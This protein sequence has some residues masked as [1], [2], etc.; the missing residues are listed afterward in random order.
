MRVVSTNDNPIAIAADALVLAKFS[1]VEWDDDSR[2]IDQAVGE[3]LTRL[4]EYERLKGSVGELTTLPAPTGVQAK[5][6]VVAGL[7]ER[8]K[9]GA[10]EIRRAFGAAAKSI[11]SKACPRVVVVAPL[12]DNDQCESA[13]VAMQVGCVGQD[14]HRAEKRLNAFDE[15][16]WRGG[17]D[18]ALYRAA[19]L[20]QAVNLTR[21][22]VN[23]P[24]NIVYPTSFADRANQVA[25]E[26]GMEIEIWDQAKLEEE[27]C[28]SLL[29]VSR[30]SSQPPRLVILRWNGGEPGDAPLALVGKG[31]TFDS[32]G[33]SLKPSEGMKTMK[34]DMAGAA[35]V[36]G[37]MSA[38]SRL[39]SPTNVVAVMGLVENMVSGD[40]YKLGDVL[41][42]RSGK[43][44]EVLNTDA[45]GRLVLADAL[46]VVQD[47][48][49]SRIIDL[50][51]LTGACLVALGT[52]VAGLMANDDDWRQ[53]VQDTAEACGEAAWPLPMF[54]AFGEQIKSQVAD[55][56]NIGE[57]RWGGSITAAKFLEEFVDD[58]IPWTHIDIAGP[59]FFDSA[60]PWIDAGGAGSFVRT[61]ARIA[62]A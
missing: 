30:G 27:K 59:A 40:S 2:A 47:D 23:E 18:A 37:A 15:I 16:A 42:A 14:L 22:L 38:I 52:E 56:K 21:E 61:L 32:G 51:T 17:D 48:K 31:V 39:K 28:G 9:C 20:G 35:T 36:L 26:C 34:C 12:L 7:G 50:A 60:K 57:G 54:A 5:Q 44:I 46:N 13:L 49:P 4:V 33:L 29:A 41:T 3:S 62:K 45:E 10:T 6:I 19:I 58:D 24:A 11:A 43:T 1:D 8:A 55:I 25:T 53:E